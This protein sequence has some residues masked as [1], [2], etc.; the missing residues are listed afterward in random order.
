MVAA[1]HTG[2][3]YHGRWA[4]RGKP[5]GEWKIQAGRNQRSHILCPSIWEGFLEE[6]S[7]PP[8][9]HCV[10]AG[11]RLGCPLVGGIWQSWSL[12]V[13]EW[14][15]TQ[16]HKLIWATELRILVCEMGCMSRGCAVTG[17]APGRRQESGNYKCFRAKFFLCLSPEIPPSLA[18]LSYCSWGT[19]EAT[20]SLG[21]L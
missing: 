12:C 17:W 18:S 5:L 10:P 16:P 21:I 4:R 1:G 11:A 6:E 15:L 7:F 9:W 8:W 20:V 19:P 14:W 2:M 3:V 13:A